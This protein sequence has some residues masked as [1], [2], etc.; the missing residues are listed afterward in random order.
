MTQVSKYPITKDI[1]DRIFDLFL[2]TFMSLKTRTEADQYISDLLTPTEK[3][4]LSKRLAI[5]FLLEKGYEYRE[6]QQLLRVSSATVSSV[7]T[8]RTLGSEG[9]KKLINKIIREEKITEF[10]EDT[11]V[12]VLSVP[13]SMGKGKSVWRY[14]KQEAETQKIKNKD[15]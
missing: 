4:M 2:K 8:T 13:A 10:L 3:V 6:I 7:N 12:R 14:L 9:Y 5:A 1:A 15:L 11:I